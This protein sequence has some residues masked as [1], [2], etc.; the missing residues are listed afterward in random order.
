M[1]N[2][3]AMTAKNH[4]NRLMVVLIVFSTLSHTS[5]FHAVP[6]HLPV[7][8]TLGNTSVFWLVSH[9]HRILGP[10]VV[11]SESDGGSGFQELVDEVD[12]TVGKLLFHQPL[13]VLAH[14]T[15]CDG[16]I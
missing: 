13:E 1:I 16:S 9:R 14:G 3:R 5:M 10:A 6:S 11:F 4:K 15:G 8:G 12:D 2:A 7:Q